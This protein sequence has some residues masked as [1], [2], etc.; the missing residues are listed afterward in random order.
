[1][2]DELTPFSGLLAEEVKKAEETP[3]GLKHASGHRVAEFDKDHA[4]K[5]AR[6]NKRSTTRNKNKSAAKARRR[7]RQ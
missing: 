2:K 5:M 7:N 6:Q 4:A 1:M 3:L